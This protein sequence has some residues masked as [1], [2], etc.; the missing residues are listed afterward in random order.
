[1]RRGQGRSY[2][3]PD[4]DECGSICT[5]LS[6]AIFVVA[7]LHQFTL[8]DVAGSLLTCLQAFFLSSAIGDALEPQQKTNRVG[9]IAEISLPL[10]LVAFYVITDLRQSV[11]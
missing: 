11:K 1:M 6:G 8:V 9:R 5:A 2:E 3:T 4:P 10:G 7:L